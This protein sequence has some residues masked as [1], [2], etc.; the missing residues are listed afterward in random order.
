MDPSNHTTLFNLE[1]DIVNLLLDKLE[2][3]DINP[4]KASIIAKF[5]LAHLPENLTDEQ[6]KQIL[7]TLDDEF[8]ELAGIVHKY[9]N[10]Y[11]DKEK[12]KITKEVHDLIKSGK[13]DEA[14]NMMKSYFNKKVQ[15]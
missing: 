2:N 3:A 13:M 14:S 1:K 9:L 8:I 4:E 12:T 5:V 7:P 6:L 11:E 15:H 10:E